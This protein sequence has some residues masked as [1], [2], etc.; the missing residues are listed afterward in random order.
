MQILDRF[1]RPVGEGDTIQLEGMGT[2]LFRVVKTKVV[3][4]VDP[5]MAAQLPPGAQV[6]ELVASA[7]AAPRAL[8]N[9]PTMEIL[10]VRDVREDPPQATPPA[11]RP[12]PL[13]LVQP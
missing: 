13:K 10:K 9:M 4:D 12:G 11:D 8:A 5:L 2:V 3:L 1:G 7:V 6:M